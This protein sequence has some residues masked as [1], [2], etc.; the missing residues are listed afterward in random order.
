MPLN[1]YFA[2]FVVGTIGGALLE[3]LHW[4]NLRK[5]NHE[6][7]SY[8]RSFAYWALSAGMTLVGGLLAVLYFG[9]QA[10]ALLAL[11][12][13]LSAPLI[14]QK[15]VTTMAEPGARSGRRK[16]LISFLTW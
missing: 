14:L 4:W 12:V 3:F 10:E 2:V 13:G 1:S 9:E 16:S 7:P 11:H 15:M 6:F 8:V 5:N